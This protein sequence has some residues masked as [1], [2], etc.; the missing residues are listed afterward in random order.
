MRDFNANVGVQEHGETKIWTYGLRHR[1]LRVQMLVNLLESVGLFVAITFFKKKP[2]QRWTWQSLDNVTRNKI[3]CIFT[4][5]KHIF[6]NVSEIDRF[7]TRSD[8]W[9][10]R[11]DLN[12][13]FKTQRAVWWNLLLDLLLSKSSW[14]L[15][16]SNGNIKIVFLEIL[17]R[18][19]TQRSLHYKSS[20]D[21][22]Y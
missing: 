3:G 10:I 4:D 2:K 9:L 18:K 19:P 15:K 16:S 8:H 1:N 14:V 5:K 7:H 13:D 17:T 6:R 11:G 21:V 12:M 20:F 22:F